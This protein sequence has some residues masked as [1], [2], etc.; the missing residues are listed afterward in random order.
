ME[1]KS[2][3]PES[4]SGKEIKRHTVTQPE[5]FNAPHLV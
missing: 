1:K 4:Q 5:M 3:S 2:K